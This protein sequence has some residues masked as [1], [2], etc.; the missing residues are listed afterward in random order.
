MDTSVTTDR[1]AS[2]A[3]VTKVYGPAANENPFRVAYEDVVD[4]LRRNELWR[5]L[6]VLD[7]KRRYRRT[8][9]GPF[10]ASGHIAL[11]IICVGF[12]FSTLLEAD[13]ATYIPYLTTGFVA[14]TFIYQMMNDAP[15]AFISA[16]SLRQ[17]INFPYSMFIFQMI[18]RGLFVHLHHY[19]LLVPVVLV[20]GLNF[21]LNTLL[22]IP[23]YILVLANMT[24]IGMLLATMASRY[25]DVQQLV[26]S[27]IQVLIYVTPIFYSI[28][29]LTEFQ[30]IW[31]LTPNLLY[32]LVVVLRSPLMGEAA[33]LSSYLILCVAFV[34]GSLFTAWFFGRRKHNIVF[35]II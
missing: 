11:Y 21:N 32:H 23:G 15:A 28:D 3:E 20:Y 17:Q 1:S 19:V 2:S 33:P 30:R 34:I 18:F 29:R 14:W 25:R 16:S 35:W 24:W 22:I 10:W 13:R 6:G 26:S 5:T 9:L 12:I 27:V 31:I 7:V 8:L 4:G